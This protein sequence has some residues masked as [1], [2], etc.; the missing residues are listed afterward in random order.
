[1]EDYKLLKDGTDQAKRAQQIHN[2]YLSASSNYELN[3][4]DNIKAQPPTIITS[5][6]P[7]S[8]IHSKHLQTR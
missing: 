1:M 8:F 2:K 3:L 6:G 5:L 7:N 4:T